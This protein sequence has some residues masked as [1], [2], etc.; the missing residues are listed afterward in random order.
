MS[1][2]SV[3][4]QLEVPAPFLFRVTGKQSIERLEPLIKALVPGAVSAEE[5]IADQ[6]ELPALDFVW[7][8]TCRREHRPIHQ[9]AA[10]TNKL[11]NAQ[12]I[13]S[14]SS[15]AYL[16]LRVDYPMLE[17]YIAEGGGEV[18]AWVKARWETQGTAQAE[19]DWWVVKASK[20][21]GGRDVWILN[22]GNADKV[23]SELEPL[24]E[25][26]IQK[27]VNHPI[28]FK[29]KKFH[30]RCYSAMMGDG[31][32]L[33]YQKSFILSA[34]MDF[35]YKDDDMR[36]HVTNLSVN[37]RFKG[38]PGQ[39]TCNMPI[40]FPEIYIEVKKMWGAIVDAAYQFM[41][42]QRGGQHFEF[43]GIDVIADSAGACWFIEANRLPGLESSSNNKDDEDV[44]Y[45]EMM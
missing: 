7:E 45:D 28:L 9:N 32:A 44:M 38:H 37:K 23:L 12:I 4:Q 21:N 30:F 29:G 1:Q 11:H 14:K 39:V 5:L 31:S 13:E 6:K 18:G 8:T 43:F 40:E 10:L 27:Y 24:E 22:A 35:D 15:L 36:K 17:T 25:Y 42:K 34:G 3:E 41:S 33:V 16:Q 2:F 20:G 26:V 19:L